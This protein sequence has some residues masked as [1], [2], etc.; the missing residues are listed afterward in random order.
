VIIHEP[1]IRQCLD[2]AISAGKKGNHTFGALLVRQGKVILTAENTVR[3]DQDSSRHAEL[4]LVVK[5]ER[6]LS[7]E[8][9]QQSTLYTS[10]A[11][12]LMCTAII[13]SAGIT[14]LAYSVSY[15][16]F[17]KLIPSEY[18]YIPC[19]EVYQRLGTAL[20]LA[21]PILEDEG[22]QVFRYWPAE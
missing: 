13:W 7:K 8:I 15:A 17:A 5:A 6:A 1:F 10:T 20:E 21:G 14:K 11:P 18:K 12:C 22:L 19:D 3:S 16:A 2:L 9:L 4:N